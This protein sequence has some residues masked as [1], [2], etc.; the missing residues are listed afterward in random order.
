MRNLALMWVLAGC[1]LGCGGR[2]AKDKAVSAVDTAVV[3]AETVNI[4]DEQQK[5]G[6]I[7]V[8]SCFSGEL[9]SPSQFDSLRM[10]D[11]EN[12]L[13][14]GTITGNRS[15]ESIHI[16]ISQNWIYFRY[17]Y[18]RHRRDKP[19]LVGRITVKFAIDG[20]GKVIF[21]RVAEST[22]NDTTF[23]NKV[24]NIIKGWVFDK[25]DKPED[26]TVVT[27]PLDCYP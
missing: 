7:N 25:I 18:N 9:I 4:N 1:L 21:A 2:N 19:D 23:E 20:F 12:A 17:A 22:V 14:S 26:I 15:K 11:V 10:V 24:V 3:A 13:N 8:S 27:L 5:Y 6:I 16:R